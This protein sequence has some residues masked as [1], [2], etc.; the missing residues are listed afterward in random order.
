MTHF[1]E[2]KPLNRIVSLSVLICFLGSSALTP[3]V[4]SAKPADPDTGSA[5]HRQFLGDLTKIQIPEEL[6]KVEEAFSGTGEKQVV[7]IQDAHSIPE[8][9]RSIQKVIDYF[10]KEYG[11]RLVALEGASGPLDPEIFK[12]FPDPE[13]LQKIF[14]EYFDRGELTDRKSVV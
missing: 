14:Q 11:F 4:A 6:G 5:P 9:Q 12:S 3:A 2:L 8:A 1:F 13:T 7:L 10:Q